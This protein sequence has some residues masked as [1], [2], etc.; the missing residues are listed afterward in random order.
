MQWPTLV[1]R[2]P[3]GLHPQECKDILARVPFYPALF[4]G[5]VV[6]VRSLMRPGTFW[7]LVVVRLEGRKPVWNVVSPY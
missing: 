7:V 6:W 5:Q 3:F 1:K 4:V 2:N